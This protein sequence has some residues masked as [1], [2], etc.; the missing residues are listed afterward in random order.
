M[1]QRMTPAV[2][3][4]TLSEAEAEAAAL[5]V[6]TTATTPATATG[7]ATATTT[8]AVGFE[9]EDWSAINYL[10]EGVFGSIDGR[11]R[12]TSGSTVWRSAHADASPYD[13]GL[14]LE[15][16]TEMSEPDKVNDCLSE[17]TSFLD[18]H[19]NSSSALRVVSHQ[20]PRLLAH[21]KWYIRARAYRMLRQRLPTPRALEYC[22]QYMELCVVHTL[23][24]D[25]SAHEEREQGLKYIRWTMRFDEE[26]WMLGP[27]VVKALMAVAEQV[28][29]RMRNICLETLCELLVLAPERLWYVNGIRTLVQAALDGP[30][31]ISIAIASTL[32]HIFDRAETRKFIHVG[33]TLGGVI[34]AL[35]E[36]QGKDQMLAERAK[37]AAFMM[38][39]LLKSWSGIQYFLSDERRMIRALLQSLSMVDSNCKII[40]GMLLELFG[41]SDEFDT[42]QFQQQPRFDVELL[43]PF[44]LPAYTIPETAARSRLLPVD[45]MRTILL[46]V[47]IDEGLVDSLI[48]VATSSDQPDVVDASSTLLKWLSQHPHMPLPEHYVAKFQ[49]LSTLVNDAMVDDPAQALNAKRVITKI[50]GIPSLSMG[51]LPSQQM[52]SWASSLASSNFYR[53]WLKRKRMRRDWRAQAAAR[54]RKGSQMVARLDYASEALAAAQQQE[55]MGAATG[56]IKNLLAHGNSSTVGGSKGLAAGLKDNAVRALRSSASTGNLKSAANANAAAVANAAMPLPT[57]NDASQKISESGSLLSSKGRRS[58]DT[59]RNPLQQHQQQSKHLPPLLLR[60]LTQGPTVKALPNTPSL[61]SSYVQ[62]DTTPNLNTASVFSQNS[63]ILS[64]LA[65]T[66]GSTLPDLPSS[67]NGLNEISTASAMPIPSSMH[68]RT[69]TKSRSRSRNSITISAEESPLAAQIKESRVT[70][71]EN[72]MRWNWETIRSIILGPIPLSR[73]LPEEAVVSAFL[74]RLSRFYHPASL[75]FCDLSRTT[76]N[77]EYLDIGRHLIRILISSA[78][79]LLLIDE[80]RLLPGIVDEILKQNN[81]ARRKIREES[82]FSF[83]RLQMTMSPGYFHFL[84][85]IDRSVGGDSLLERTRLFDAY[86]QVVELPDQVLLIQYI[87]ASMSYSTDGHARN[88]L[89]KV[90]SSPHETLRLL[91]PSFLL[92]LASDSPC[93]PGSVSAWVIEVLLDL[94]Y[95]SSPAVRS[96]AAQCLVLVIDMSA[97]NPYLN[98]NESSIRIA[99]LL[100]LRPMFDLAV[101]TDIRPLILRLIGTESGFSYLKSQGIVESEMDTWGALEGIFHVQSI[102]LDI[103]RALAYGPLFSSTPDGSMMMTTSSQTPPTPAH[104]FGELTCTEGGR[105]FLQTVGIPQILFETLENIP[106]DSSLP[107]DV[108]ALKATLWAIGAMGGASRDGY[109]MLEPYNVIEK[110]LEVARS[111]SSLSLKGT[112]MYTLALLSRNSFAAEVFREKGWLLCSSCYGNYEFAVPKRLES[113]LNATGWA[114]QG[115]LDNTYV[116]SEGVRRDPDITDELDSVQKEIIDAVILMSNHVMVNT[117]SKTL[118]RLRTSHPHYFRLVPLYCKAMHLL[119]KYRYRL[120]TRRFIYDVFDVNLASL[121]EEALDAVIST[122]ATDMGE[123]EFMGGSLSAGVDEASLHMNRRFSSSSQHFMQTTSDTQRKR[124]STLQGLSSSGTTVFSRRPT[125]GLD[126]IRP[127]RAGSQNNVAMRVPPTPITSSDANMS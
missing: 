44:H 45:Y 101:I 26:W 127:N 92:Y 25:D 39:Q 108:T 54:T 117:A 94:I 19:A 67:S 17:M 119:G 113:I 14:P 95:D 86:Y 110:L 84:S 70:T 20:V 46:M 3:A 7:T 79:G 121:H 1:S 28:D 107:A 81:Y 53:H 56:S 41:L 35:T 16:C 6:N 100:E 83:A 105:G 49:T 122:T 4:S 57:A 124:A 34:S 18:R 31:T 90:A 98:R 24:R 15:N 74:T 40:L 43:S 33:I 77:E 47:F 82:C 30:W 116:F 64:V 112:C 85:E 22:R 125:N 69:R 37:V 5:A 2:A 75:E 76:D 10:N 21:Y 8:P 73:R 29:D 89:R 55:F 72:P 23:S 11:T 123:S 52:D 61:Q 115:L 65:T 32:S 36:P 97:E 111:T 42:I 104:L 62:I 63:S 38:T 88:I 66:P 12:S 59:V 9:M 27:R 114:T 58:L 80:S 50:E 60:G 109:L 99:H 78:D 68:S 103:A 120:S 13:I 93:R 91:V 102:E 96:A 51:Q 87:L 106:W 71:E 126:D 48:N 118:M